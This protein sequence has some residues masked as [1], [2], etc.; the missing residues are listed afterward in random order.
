LKN[1][2]NNNKT[3]LPWICMVSVTTDT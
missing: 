2:N 3:Q 1:N